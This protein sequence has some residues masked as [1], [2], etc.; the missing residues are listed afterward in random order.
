M[1]NQPR[2]LVLADAAIAAAEHHFVQG[3]QGARVRRRQQ[4]QRV[5]DRLR[6]EQDVLEDSPLV[7]RRD[8]R[9]GACPSALT[10]LTRVVPI[11][12]PRLRPVDAAGR[13][14][15]GG[16]GGG[17]N[18]IYAISSGGMVHVLNVQTGEDLNP[19]MQFLPAGRKPSDPCR[20]ARWSTL[21]P[22][23]IAAARRTACTRSISRQKS[24]K[25]WDAKGA[26]I[27]GT[28]APTFG[29]DGTIYV[30][31]SGG[32]ADTANAVVALD[33]TALTSKD[34][35]SAGSPF[36]SA[37]IVFQFQGKDM[38]AAA[39]R[40]GRIYLL[41]GASLGGADHKTALAKSAP[42]TASTGDFTPGALATWQD[43]DGTRWIAVPSS[44]PASPDAKLTM[45]NGAVTTGAIVDVQG[46]RN[47]PRRR[48]SRVGCRGT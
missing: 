32:S 33:S 24:V 10:T 5:L 14:G 37:P 16:F 35:F 43:A 3:L 44:G 30:A 48:W 9:H 22:R 45:T 42:Y 25:S 11:R 23:T 27:A 15:G 36:V 46:H 19:P 2:Q 6:P 28:V 41:D 47:G 26:A 7:R 40:D 4:R 31:T 1:D 21:R 34:W 38:V 39:N 8:G 20:R 17:N 18:N 29:T 12:L 13:G